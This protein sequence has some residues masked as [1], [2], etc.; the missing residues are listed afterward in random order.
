MYRKINGNLDYLLE[1][2]KKAD[3]NNVK[4][5]E[6]EKINEALLKGFKQAYRGLTFKKP[7]CRQLELELE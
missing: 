6:L 1:L 7:L 2:N 5:A 4:P 3:R